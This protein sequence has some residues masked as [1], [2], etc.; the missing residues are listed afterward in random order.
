MVLAISVA[1]AVS[2]FIRNWGKAALVASIHDLEDQKSPSLKTG[3]KS[4]L[5][6]VKRFI[7]LHI[8]PWFIWAIFAVL[9]LI[10]AVGGMV[11]IKN[12]ESG[13]LKIVISIFGIL[14]WILGLIA[15]W[16]FLNLSVILGEQLI[17]RQN[18]SAK[19]ALKKGFSLTRKYF[20]EMLGMGAINMG[21]GCGFGCL[22]T[23]FLILLVIITLIAFAIG[24]TA[25][26]VVLVIIAIPIFALLLLS[27][28]IRGIY[29]VFNTAT[30]TLLAREIEQKEKQQ[31]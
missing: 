9:L 22:T 20:A 17:V 3:S 25:G 5:A 10:L 24:K 23:L 16:L 30:W 2:L 13:V 4:G 6:V 15:T 31:A 28:L 12:L 27:L 14:I 11:Y 19:E 26:F 1:V 18:I 7:Y 21:I 8:F 29:T